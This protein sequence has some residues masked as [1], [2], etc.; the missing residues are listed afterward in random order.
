MT[1]KVSCP[2]CGLCQR[3]CVLQKNAIQVTADGVVIDLEKCNRCGHCVA[4]CPTG[5][6]NHPCSLL[7]EEAGAPLSP[8]AALRFL[9]TPRSV[10]R[11]KPE[12]V[13][14]EELAQLL[15]AGRY[16]PTAKNSQGVCYVVLQGREKVEQ[17]GRLYRR[18]V[19]GLPED[20]SQKELLERPV[21]AGEERGFDGL[22]YDC[23]Q[24]VFA[25]CDKDNP[26]G[27][28]NAQFSLTYI[29]LLAPS[30]GLG[31]CWS[32]QLERVA[33][34]GEHMETF[35]RLIGLGPDKT[36]CGCLMVG[37]P[38]VRFLR[39]VDRAPLEIQWS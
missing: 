9:R 28:R 3:E 30:L 16:P 32:G 2:A 15:N 11:F 37:Y 26:N 39:L 27:R 10:R 18:I 23:P 5:S 25:V 33:C 24:L 8:E 20:Y 14:R 31:T 12:P 35:A 21:L 6:M 19:K 29:T 34:E 4:I 22:F 7:Q 13:P 36:I 38:A 17:V 1:C